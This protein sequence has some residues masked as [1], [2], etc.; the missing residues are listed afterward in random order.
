MDELSDVDMQMP[1]LVD[2]VD[3]DS[4]HAM[5]DQ[6][7]FTETTRAETDDDQFTE[8]EDEDHAL[9]KNT[10]RHEMLVGAFH[11]W[12]LKLLFSKLKK[13]RPQSSFFAVKVKVG[14]WPRWRHAQ[15]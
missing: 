9:W 4:D 5:T 15:W 11:H 7:D 6:S 10:S 3:S 14:R 8:S 12:F 2:V 13:L 1:A